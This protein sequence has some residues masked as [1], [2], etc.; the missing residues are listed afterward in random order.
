MPFFN[1]GSR[2]L[3]ASILLENGRKFEGVWRGAT[4]VEVTGEIVFNTSMTGY[5]E[6]LTDPSYAGQIVT[7]TYPEIGN[8]GTNPTDVESTKT[9]CRG[10]IVR[11]LSEISSNF[12]AA[13]TLEEYLLNNNLACMSEVDTRALTRQLRETGA[14]KGTFLRE[15][16]DES[17]AIE[18]IKGFDYEGVDHSAM[19]SG[20]QNPFG[21]A[22]EEGRRKIGVIDFGIKSNILRIISSFANCYI[23]KIE[24]FPMEE[25]H[26]F[27]GFF[28]SNGPGDPEAV[29]GAKETIQKI[30]DQNK[31]TFGICL[32]HQ[33]LC[34]TLGAETFKLKFGHHGAN[35][36]VKNHIT[37][38]VEISSQNH[39]FAVK[40]G[41][42]PEDL[43]VLE[44]HTN[45][46]DGSLAGIMLKDR[47]VYSIQYH[48]EA[49]PGPNDSQYLFNK[50]KEDLGL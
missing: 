33:L 5:Q 32:G 37:T 20:L 50:F 22:Y 42:F 41:S 8:Y 17:Q 6:I 15:G 24:N 2:V 40:S 18:R 23:Y 31:P 38:Q 39:G 16:E 36:P 47:P 4:D 3:K 21:Y 46:N 43:Q 48:P 26:T 49:A 12:T 10:L 9:H 45:L 7:M 29:V 25:I 28:L 11:E 34:L 14:M 19:V 27:D 13:N 1:R 35:H 44:T 30:L